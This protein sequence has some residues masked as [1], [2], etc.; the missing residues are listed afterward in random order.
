MSL[1]TVEVRVIKLLYHDESVELFLS[2]A[3]TFSLNLALDYFGPLKIT[4]T[5]VQCCF[6]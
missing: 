6:S 2:S 4:Y 5:H 1:F 3:Q